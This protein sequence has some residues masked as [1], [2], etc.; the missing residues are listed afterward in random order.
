MRVYQYNFKQTDAKLIRIS[1]KKF[2]NMPLPFLHSDLLTCLNL[3][4]ASSLERVY[5]VFAS[6]VPHPPNKLSWE[7]FPL[8]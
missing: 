2:N 3:H 5:H 7:R 4:T 6:P 1:V 8:H